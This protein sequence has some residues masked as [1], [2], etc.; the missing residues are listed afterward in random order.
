M[1]LVF[2]VEDQSTKVM[3]SGLLPRVLPE[4]V[5]TTVIAFEGKSDLE[6][7]LPLKLRGWRTPDCRFIVIRDQDS[8]DCRTVKSRLTEICTTAGKP[9]T[10]VRVACHELESWYLGDLLAVEQGLG[11]PG[12][13]VQQMSS[14]LRSPDHLNNAKE[15]LIRITKQVYQE[16]GGSRSIGPHLRTDSSNLSHSFQVFLAGVRRVAGV[17]T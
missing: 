7:H 17:S 11:I 12:L 2:F 14:T 9:E 13:S 3:L 6:A 8:A 1:N 15:V 4:E 5:Q 10:L 16:V